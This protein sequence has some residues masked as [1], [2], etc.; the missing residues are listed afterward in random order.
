MLFNSLNF[1][2]FICIFFSIYW[3][4]LKKTTKGQNI[5]ILIGSYIFY[6]WWDYRFLGLIFLSSL[7]DFFV[8]INLGKSRDKK[9]RKLLIMASLMVNLG[10]LVFFKYCNFFIDSFVDLFYAFGVIV[11][12]DRLEIILPAGI[13]FYT[14]QTMSYSIDVYKKEMK[15]TS[16]FIEFFAFVSFFPQLV[17]GPIERASYLLPQFKKEKTLSFEQGKN[18]LRQILW[19][20]VKKALIADNCAEI[21][22]YIFNNHQGLG[23]GVLFAGGIFFAF[24]IYC[25]FSGYSDI[26]IGTSKLLGFDLMKNFNFPYFS[27]NIAEFWRKWHISL[28][29]WFRDYLYIPLGGGRSNKIRNIFVIFLVSG[30]WHGASWNFIFWGLINALLFLPTIYLKLENV[31]SVILQKVFESS[32]FGFISMILTFIITVF[33]WLFFRADTL[34][35]ALSM[36]SEILKSGFII[37][38]WIEFYDFMFWNYDFNIIG[39]LLIFVVIEWFGRNNDFAIEKLKGNKVIRWSFYYLLV[40]S[41]LYFNG[42]EETFIYFQF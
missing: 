17:A 12:V 38:S 31:K 16:N 24:Q 4:L 35:Q 37:K 1:L 14:F 18:A 21:A 27:R 33:A 13:S 41:I 3:F 22:N 19:G 40:Y 30:F 42:P 8:G 11:D 29:T 5:F 7:V 32:I 2:L 9:S 34:G 25:D 28:T 26:A 10:G 39:F 15:P 6:G 23:G 20:L 36:G